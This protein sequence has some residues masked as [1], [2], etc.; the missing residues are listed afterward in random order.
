MRW[1]DKRVVTSE[2]CW[3]DIEERMTDMSSE[4]DNILEGKIW[5]SNQK[6]VM[7]DTINQ[8]IVMNEE[9]VQNDVIKGK[10]VKNSVMNVKID[11][12]TVMD[13]SIFRVCGRNSFLS[14]NQIL[15]EESIAKN[16]SRLMIGISS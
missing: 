16:E 5:N 13:L 10:F 7:D 14:I 12:K 4:V 3:N 8:K 6:I 1:R 11:P 15:L 9:F 2:M